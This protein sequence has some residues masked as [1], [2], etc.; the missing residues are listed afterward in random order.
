MKKIFDDETNEYIWHLT[1][2]D[3]EEET[4]FRTAAVYT[5]FHTMKPREMKNF[6]KEH[7][8]EVTI[9]LTK[10]F[11]DNYEEYADI[12]EPVKLKCVKAVTE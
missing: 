9:A 3:N 4:Y 12:F 11:L 10:Y 1:N 2:A 5:T 8:T 6:Y 7:L